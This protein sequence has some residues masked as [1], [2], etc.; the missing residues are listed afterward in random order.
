MSDVCK[1]YGEA[2]A[3][4]LEDIAPADILEYFATPKPLPF[5]RMVPLSPWERFKTFLPW[6]WS[7]NHKTKWVYNG[8]ATIKFI[9]GSPFDE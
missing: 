8:P 2:V 7:R 4:L 5:T 1:T 6:S 3:R 9:R